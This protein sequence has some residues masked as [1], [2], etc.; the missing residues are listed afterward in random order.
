MR[1]PHPPVRRLAAPD[2]ESGTVSDSGHPPPAGLGPAGGRLVPGRASTAASPAPAFPVPS[3]P[4]SASTGSASTGSTPPGSHGSWSPRRGRAGSPAPSPQGARPARPA[5]AAAGPALPPGVTLLL[6]EQAPAASPL[7]TPPSTPLSASPSGDRTVIPAGSPAPAAPIGVFVPA[8]TPL[9]PGTSFAALRPAPPARR[10]S[11]PPPPTAGAV[12]RAL[13]RWH[14]SG[15]GSRRG[16]RE[17]GIRAA[18]S[19]R[20][21]L[22]GA[23]TLAVSALTATATAYPAAAMTGPATSTPATSAPAA[24]AAAGAD[25]GGPASPGASPAPQGHAP[26]RILLAEPSGAWPRGVDVS[27]WQH[28]DGEPIDWNAVR[29]AGIRFAIIK[30]TEGTSYTNPYFAGDRADAAAAGLGVGAYHYARPALPISTAVDQARHF[31]AATGQTRTPGHLAPVLDIE[32]TGGLDAKALADWTRAFLEEVETQTGRTPIIYTYRSFW[33]DQMGNTK[34]FAQYPFWFA[35]YNNQSTPG[36]LPGGWSN[37]AIWQYTSS[38]TVAGIRGDVDMNVVC[39]T[40]AAL[41]ALADGVPSEIDKRYASAG[42]MALAVGAPVDTERPAGGGGR[43]R[44]HT[45]GLMFWS[46]ATGARIVHGPSATKYLEL[47]GSNSFLG[48]PVSDT[49]LATAPGAHQTIFQ[50]GWIYWH[51]ETGAHEVHG[52]ILKTYLGMGGSGS[53]LGLPITDEYSVPGGRE[54]AFQFGRLRWDAATN[55]VTVIDNAAP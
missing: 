44:R 52:A 8:G 49:E 34:E 21:H 20:R 46:A 17:D 48:R 50:G 12:A 30:A 45:N 35:I 6:A 47:G 13:A 7:S 36:W 28:P 26:D 10:R 43:W 24:A 11:A 25:P 27:S 31:L 53:R 2:P 33:T 23:A 19:R 42:L 37:W 16:A 40:E 1:P 41:T 15:G 38:G 22:L 5:A 14:R 51:P 3:S 18:G 55:E 54:S 29:N 4:A 32:V 9:P 39:C